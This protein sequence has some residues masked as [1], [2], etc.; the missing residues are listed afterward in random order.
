MIEAP[1]D[2]EQVEAWRLDVLV[3]GGYP[4]WL[5]KRLARWLDIDL[6]RAVELVRRGCQPELAAKILL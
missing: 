6:H 2:V 1:E 3:K 5:A 4:Q